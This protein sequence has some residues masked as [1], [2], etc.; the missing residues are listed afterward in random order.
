MGL[1]ITLTSQLAIT[2]NDPLNAEADV[3]GTVFDDPNTITLEDDLDYTLYDSR[4]AKID[5]ATPITFTP[6]F[7]TIKMVLLETNQAI[8][9]QITDAGGAKVIEGIEKIFLSFGTFTEIQITATV[10]NTY[11][12]VI[13]I[14]S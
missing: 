11:A 9:V 8:D 7:S 5:I 3:V 14:G 1:N 12:K 6:P 13:F 2:D 4:S 10:D